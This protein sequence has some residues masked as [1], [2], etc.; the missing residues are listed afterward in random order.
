MQS[1]MRQLQ[2]FVVDSSV[3]AVEQIDIDGSRNVLWMIAFVL[4]PLADIRPDLVL[5]REKKTVS[6]LLADF[7]D[8]A[9]VV[10]FAESW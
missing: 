7:N 6:E 4:R 5:L 10:R 8:S 9:A 2:S 1:R 3:S